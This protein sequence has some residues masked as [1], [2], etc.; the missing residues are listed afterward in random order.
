MEAQ[1]TFLFRAT[2]KGPL[3]TALRTLTRHQTTITKFF[4]QSI[5]QK[6][7]FSIDAKRFEDQ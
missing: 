1:G 4:L 5:P 7:K 6:I 2:T 3:V